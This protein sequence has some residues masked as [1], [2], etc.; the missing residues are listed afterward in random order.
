MKYKL[1][2]FQHWV[3]IFQH[4][5]CL[6]ERDKSQ[7]QIH[8]LIPFYQC[9]FSPTFFTSILNKSQLQ[10]LLV[11]THADFKMSSVAQK[12]EH[13][14][15]KCFLLGNG[16]FCCH[17]LSPSHP[18]CPASRQGCDSEPSSALFE[19]TSSG[20]RPVP[21]T[22]RLNDLLKT[23]LFFHLFFGKY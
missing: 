14:L 15:Q 8:F 12:Q 9:L 22:R 3:A 19:N 20:K 23:S 10:I 13:L 7:L 6:N 11:M 2:C 17:S 21:K 16:N 1:K 5:F 18:L 4:N